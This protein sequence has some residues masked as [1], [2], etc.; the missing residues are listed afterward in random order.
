MVGKSIAFLKM[1]ALI[2]KIADC[3][4]PVLLEGETGTGKELVA[5]AIHYQG[6]RRDQPFVPVNCGAI[7]DLLIENELFG[8]RKG[9]FTDA[10]VDQPGLIAHA[11]SGTLFLDEVDALSPKGQV[12]LLRFLQ[13]QHYRPLGE[14]REQATDVRIIAASNAGLGALAEAGQF[15]RDLL[16]RL[17]ILFL[18]VP[19][20]RERPGDSVLLAE[21]FARVGSQRFGKPSITLDPATLAWIETYA[22]PGNIRELENWVYRQVLL[23]D[24]PVIHLNPIDAPRGDRRRADRRRRELDALDYV[25][26]KAKVL[27]DFEKQFLA[28]VLAKA[29]GNVT[30]AAQLAG[31]ER[32]YLGKLLK[33]RGL[34]KTHYHA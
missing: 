9:A 10:R 27:E 1:T 3:D 4:A 13:D 21:H 8:H 5:R 17:K 24:D 22:W 29:Q 18:E 15:R 31:T 32:R 16:Y 7:P 20:L 26:A 25:T 28:S 23:A 34:D 33:K 11:R 19:P 12:T 6:K 30:A 2:A 14:R